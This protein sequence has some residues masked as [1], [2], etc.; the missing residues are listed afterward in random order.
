MQAQLGN[1]EMIGSTECASELT[2]YAQ[3]SGYTPLL[4]GSGP[5]H[6][7]TFF[8]RRWLRFAGE[9]SVR[10]FNVSWHADLHPDDISQCLH[11]HQRAFIKRCG[12]YLEF[13]VR[14]TKG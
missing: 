11:T 2:G 10:E 3:L 8:N 14:D 4:W 1:G 9:P 6:F 7:C 5:Y 13:R 12:F